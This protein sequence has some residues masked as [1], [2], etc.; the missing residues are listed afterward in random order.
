MSLNVQGKKNKRQNGAEFGNS[1]KGM[2]F[3]VEMGINH[4]KIQ[5]SGH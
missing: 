4:E 2:L 5:Y 1:R 3:K